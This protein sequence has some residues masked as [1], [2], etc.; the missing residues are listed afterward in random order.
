MELLQR[1]GIKGIAVS[2][3]H[4]QTNVITNWGHKPI[5]DALS[6]MSTRGLKRWVKN[7][8]AVAL[9]MSQ[10]LRLRRNDVGIRFDSQRCSENQ[11]TSG[12]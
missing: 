1:P 3:Y 8:H 5:V 9:P 6:K 11:T 4:P 10:Q 2:A 12:T 7:V